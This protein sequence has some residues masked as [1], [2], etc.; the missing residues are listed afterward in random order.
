MSASPNFL[1]ELTWRGLLHQ[2]AGAHV[3]TH[4]HTP[5]VGYCGFDPTKDSLTI[6]NFI[7]I[8][9]LM[10]WQRA[11]HR[12]IV[13][14]GG[15]TGLIG[16]P[17]GKDA[18]R[19]LI[20]AD[21]VA[22]NIAGQRR[23]FEKL[24]DCDPT[25][26]VRLVNNADWLLKLGFIEIL[27]DVGKHFSV[28]AMIQRDAVRDRLQNREQGISYTEFSYVLMQAFDFVHLYR[29]YGCTVQLAGSDQYG[30]IVAGMDLIRRMENGEGFGITNPLVTKA[31]GTKIGKTADGAIWLTADRTSPYR[32]YQY[33]L[34]CADEDALRF[35]PWYTFLE[36]S[37]IE[38]LQQAHQAQP[39]L[40]LAQK[41]LAAEMTTL[42]HD[43][44]ALKRAEL[45]TEVLFGTGEVRS[46]DAATLAEI[47]DDIPNS[48]IPH[49]RLA[50]SGVLLSELLAE[51]SLAT[52]RRQAREFIS[53][54]AIAVNG[55][56]IEADR[57]LTPH[58]L[59]DGGVILLKRGKKQWHGLRRG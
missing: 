18:E 57:A 33:W 3:E 7:A 37:E 21:Q 20:T 41:T 36:Q 13:L 5:R 45:A 50:E 15:G 52:S 47:L 43:A 28:N 4:L 32:F 14:M 56:K 58:D 35:L 48:E 11:G 16:D 53:G 26:G 59:L 23:V 31:D 49:E 8:K 46:L 6:G 25:H 51:T 19:Q 55:E 44:A 1:D 27:R 38:S 29:E 24:L 17:S 30:N 10:H 34:N 42:I 2:T 12:P 9:L 39:H 54:G 22:A 40:R